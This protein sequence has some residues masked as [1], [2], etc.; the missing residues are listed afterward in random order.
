ML[1]LPAPSGSWN[2]PD[3]LGPGG[4][5]MGWYW[6]GP[7]EDYKPQPTLFGFPV[8]EREAKLFGRSRWSERIS[9]E[10]EK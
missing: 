10:P 2:I 1:Q 7:L 9:S 6:F 3:D 4:A 5:V 8:C